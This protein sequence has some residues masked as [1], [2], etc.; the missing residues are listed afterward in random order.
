MFEIGMQ[1]L[2]DGSSMNGRGMLS[3]RSTA[4]P[5]PPPLQLRKELV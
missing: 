3:L 2:I 5:L 1:A 4:I